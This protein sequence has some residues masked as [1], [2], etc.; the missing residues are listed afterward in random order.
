ASNTKG[1]TTLLLARLVDAQNLQWNQH[2]IQVYPEF[3]LGDPNTTRQVEVKQLVCA[4]TCLPRQDLEWIFRFKTYT[5]ASTF[6]LLATMQ[7]TSRFGE[8]FQYSN[9]M[10]AAAGYIGASLTYPGK[11]P[12][13]AYDEAM[14]TRVFEPLGMT[15]TT[16]DFSRALKGNVAQPH[17][18][19]VD[20]KLRRARM[21]LNESVVPVRPAGGVWTSAH[22][23]SKDVQMEL[24]KGVVPSG[25]RLVAEEKLLA[26]RAP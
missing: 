24:A 3:K 4:C 6:T 16:F 9:L 26:R 8:V 5:P 11:E 23:L 17:A 13:A 1:M 14:R 7:P 19:D 20:G 15:N 10:A 21:D 2:V 12:G 25:K 22:D 18:E